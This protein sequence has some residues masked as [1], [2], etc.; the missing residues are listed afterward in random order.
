MVCAHLSTVYKEACIQC[1]SLT[2]EDEGVEATEMSIIFLT[3]VCALR[4]DPKGSPAGKMGA[5]T[6]GASR[7]LRFLADLGIASALQIPFASLS[8]SQILLTSVDFEEEGALA[9]LQYS[10]LLISLLHK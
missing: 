2:L 8:D 3:F 10:I 1:A 5:W 7:G 6:Q 9:T 4:Y